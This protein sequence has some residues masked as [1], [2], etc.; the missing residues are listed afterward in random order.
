MIVYLA[1][2]CILIPFLFATENDGTGI[3]PIKMR[4]CVWII[5]AADLTG[6]FCSRF[7]IKD[8]LLPDNSYLSEQSFDNQETTVEHNQVL[9]ENNVTNP[10]EKEY[11]REHLK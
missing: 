7:D 3:K 5:L 8:N 9:E 10:V 4:D 2:F 11:I 6:L 1:V